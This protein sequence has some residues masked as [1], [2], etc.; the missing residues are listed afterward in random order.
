MIEL[1]K[2]KIINYCNLVKFSHTIFALPFTLI[3][4]GIGLSKVNFN[5]RWELLV[6]IVVGFTALRAFAM[7][8]NRYVD[9]KT[10]AQN[11]RT[12]SREMPKRL[13]TSKEVFSF[14]LINLLLYFVSIAQINTVC[15]VLSPI[16]VGCI[17][18]YSYSKY[19]TALCHLILGLCLGFAPIGAGL[20]VYPDF[21]PETLLIGL[22]VLCW[23]AGFD[24]IYALS[25]YEFDCSHNIHSLPALLGISKSLWVSRI[26]HSVTAGLIILTAILFNHFGWYYLISAVFFILLLIIQHLI[27]IVYKLTK[28]NLAFFTFNGFA[29]ILFCIGY[30]LEIFLLHSS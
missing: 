18:L 8:L 12:Q 13:L 16:P 1:L 29:S 9:R 25:D 23:V 26:L 20:A 27:I 10:D 21:L 7:G 6:F 15:F 17:I 5:F 24:I 4:F 19:F 11:P 30:L 22:T 2:K 3:G 14:T 28:I